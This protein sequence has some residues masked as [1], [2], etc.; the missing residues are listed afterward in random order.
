[1]K[2][3]VTLSAL[4]AA[5]IG[6][7]GASVVQYN[8]NGSAFS[9]TSAGVGNGTSGVGTVLSV[10]NGTA[11]I[12]LTYNGPGAP[13]TANVILGSPTNLSYGYFDLN[14]TGSG[15]VNVPSFTFTVN[16]NDITTGLSGNFAGFATPAT[17]TA[18]TSTINIFYTPLTFTLTPDKFVINSPTAIV[19]PTSLQGQASIQGSVSNTTAPEPGTMFLMGAGLIGVAFTARKKFANRG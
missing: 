13:P 7:A 15:T 16:V 8:T 6:S 1:M 5:T 11:G 17:V 10:S 4:V 14:Y 19:A 9:N 2:S 3:L 18:N 12:T